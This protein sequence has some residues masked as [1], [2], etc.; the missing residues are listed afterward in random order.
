MDLGKFQ[1]VAEVSLDLDEE[2]AYNPHIASTLLTPERE[3]LKVYVR[4]GQ[5]VGAG[6]VLAELDKSEWQLALQTAENDLA[7]T[8][9]EYIK[10]VI[11][12]GGD[13]SQAN[14][15][16]DP[17]LHERIRVRKGLKGVELKVQQAQMQLDWATAPQCFN[18]PR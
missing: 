5:K 6:Q 1:K 13:L 9:E 3:L 17:V 12:Y 2:S 8:R 18:N 14:A 15:G 10:E 11:D 4:N 7:L 16:I